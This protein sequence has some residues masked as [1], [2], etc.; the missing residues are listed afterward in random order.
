MRSFSVK[1]NKFQVLQIQ[2]FSFTI[3]YHVRCFI[4]LQQPNDGK[5]KR[6]GNKNCFVKAFKWYTQVWSILF[7]VHLS[8]LITSQKS[9][10][11]ATSYC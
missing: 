8:E 6:E 10:L 9:F 2:F 11:K 4:Y 1:L 5:P 7:I 3:N